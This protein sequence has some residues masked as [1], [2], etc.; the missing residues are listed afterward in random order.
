MV[1]F[2]RP[3]GKEIDEEQLRLVLKTGNQNVIKMHLYRLSRLTR[4]ANREA[5]GRVL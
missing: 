1:V 2:E 3:D 4:K 5:E